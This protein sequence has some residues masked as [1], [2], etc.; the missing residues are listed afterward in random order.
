[1]IDKRLFKLPKAKIMLAMLAGLMFL[2]AFAILGQ[3]I[4]LSRAIVG[5]W[6]RQSFANIAEDVLTFLIFYLLRQGIN[7]FQKWYMNRY[8]NQTTALLRQQLLNKTYDGGIA[9]VSRIGTGNLVSTLLDGMD[10]ISN[11]LSLIFP[12]LIALAIVPWV[13]LIYI[14][15][16]NALSG[17][18]LLLVF[19]LLILFMIILGTAAQSKASKQYAGYIKLQNHFVDALRGLSTLKVLGLAK[20]YGNIVYKNSENY[21]KKTM[22][23]LRVAILSTFTLDFFTT[24]SIAMIAMFLGIGLINGNLLL[25]PSLVILILSPEYFLP[26][27]DFGNDFHATLNGKNA[28]GQIFDILAFP[29]TPQENQLSSFTWNKDSTFIA[30]NVSFNYSHIDQDHFSVNKNAKMSAVVKKE[31]AS[32]DKTHTADE[33]RNVNLNLTGF[34]KVGI[35]GPTGAGKTTLMRILAG[36]LTPHLKEDNFTINGQNLAQ[37]NQKNWQNQITYIPQDPFMFAT[38]IKENLTFYNPSASQTEIDAA[39]KAT[40]LNNFVASLKDG[41]NTRI[42]ENGRGISGGQK[43]RI[44]LARAFL[45][46]DRKVLF[47]DEPTAHLDIETEYELKEPMKKLMENHLVF[48]TTHR[49]HWLNDMD[50]CLVIEDGEIVEQGT[51]SDL[52]KN[53]TLFKKLTQPLKEDLL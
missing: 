36:F 33:L 20:K 9:L 6:K 38:S 10:E 32:T 28:L 50:W 22:G 35:I 44:A 14:F 37:L 52:A 1:M 30:N 29:T 18:I 53:G 12:K 23:V 45:A 43:Q 46:K 4:F 49:L 2:Q 15:T 39:L 48:F 19:P 21:R 5:S 31:Q 16:L 51:P 3:G 27:R 17:W 34:Q 40:N 8:A 7:W 26:I 11:Y 41:L 47:F 24:L 25:Y 13:I 42:G